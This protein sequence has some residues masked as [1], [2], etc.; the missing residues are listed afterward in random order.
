MCSIHCLHFHFAEH[1]YSFAI[2]EWMLTYAGLVTMSKI[3]IWAPMLYNIVFWSCIITVLCLFVFQMQIDSTTISN[4][5]KSWTNYIGICNHFT[6]NCILLKKVHIVSLWLLYC[7]W[8]S[9]LQWYWIRLRPMGFDEMQLRTLF[10]LGKSAVMLINTKKNHFEQSKFQAKKKKEFS[11][12]FTFSSVSCDQFILFLFLVFC[13][14]I[15]G[16]INGRTSHEMS[17]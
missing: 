15:F 12:Q 13:S 14:I 7:C 10:Y 3:N 9:L 5:K 8:H 11:P 6:K 16:H 4:W 2:A 17:Q 1:F